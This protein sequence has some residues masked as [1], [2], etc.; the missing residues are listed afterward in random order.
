MNP[1][2]SRLTAVATR[3]AAAFAA[4]LALAS[5]GGGGVSANPSPIVD[6]PT[7]TILPAT[8]VVYSGLPTTFVFSGG[9]GA[10]IIASSNQ[11]I[12]PAI[13]G[14]TGRSVMLVP[15]PVTVDTEVTLTLRD[16]GTAAPVT[17]TVT[18][19]PG[20]VN[21]NIDVAFTSNACSPALCSGGDALVSVT[22][23]QGGV[24]LA[25]RGVR[26]EVVSGQ[27]AVITTPAGTVP[28]VTA[29]SGTTAT[30]ET[31][32]A[33]MRVRAAALAPNQTAVLRIV[34]LATLAYRETSITI[35]Q[36]GGAAG[37][38][39][40]IPESVAFSGPR[41]NVCASGASSDFFIF[42]GTPPYTVSNPGPDALAA[43]PRVVPASGGSFSVTVGSAVCPSETI[44]PITDASGR[45][46]T[47]KVTNSAGTFVPST[48]TVSPGELRLESCTDVGTVTIIGGLGSYLQPTSN[49]STVLATIRN[50][51]V[52]IKRL[53]PSGVPPTNLASVVVS[54]GLSTALIQVTLDLAALGACP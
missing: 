25:A 26:F 16:T 15:N 22:L 44:I 10:Y 2:F 4:A 47:V 11:A 14:V 32:K 5:C 34:D 49:T 12:L 40:A 36:S 43:S 9:T 17:A 24:P 35:A 19:R 8:A 6:S 13:G 42:G 21:N 41:I 53:S 23:S 31:G 37:G 33:R 38:Y 3:A 7:L 48:V 29:S 51:T 52:T 20:T 39:F 27:L 50:N 28:E 30:D 45:T 46:I 18:V 54:D 1:T